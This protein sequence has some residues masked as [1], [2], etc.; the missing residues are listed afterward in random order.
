MLLYHLGTDR[1]GIVIAVRTYPVERIV[2]S[3]EASIPEAV[4]LG[5]SERGLLVGKHFA[6][7]LLSRDARAGIDTV[8]DATTIRLPREAHTR[9]SNYLPIWLAVE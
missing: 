4:T 9:D 8:D 5:F 6:L 3:G 7:Q 2:P 1:T